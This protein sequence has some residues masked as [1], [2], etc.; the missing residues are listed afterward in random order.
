MM[1]YLY[2][3][4]FGD[5]S[6]IKRPTI[7]LIGVPSSAGARRTGQEKAPAAIRARG[8]VE[9]LRRK[10]LTVNDLGDLPPVAFRPDPEH[11]R[12]QNLGLVVDVARQVADRVEGAI[13]SGAFPL[14]LGGD[15][16]LGL[17]AIAGVL[18]HEERLGLL[19]CDSDLDLNTPETTPSGVFEG[20]VVAHALGRGAPELAGIG[21]RCPLL[22]EEDIVLF[23]Y[24]AESG[25]VDPPEL[26][27]LERSRM[28]KYPVGRVRGN[29]ASAAR[30]ALRHLESRAKA[31]LVHF[32]I[33]VM[34]FPAV[35]VPH[36]QPLDAESTFAAL[37][38]FVTAP[39]CAGLVV[40][41]LNADKDPDGIHTTKLVDG[42][43]EV[44]G[45]RWESA[46]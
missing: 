45:G 1:Y 39:S 14:V 24:D 5:E 30:D 4:I 38:V 21:P 16:S 9:R 3:M 13:A 27:A 44:L 23:G 25:W 37:K 2:T 7:A 19:Y 43:V 28:S 46:S 17:G 36:P 18:R 33:D 15:C 22:N 35:D 29:A 12:Q 32:D 34:D 31:V 8:L 42:L 20:M 10:G 6:F 41:E 40:T 26:E 11:P